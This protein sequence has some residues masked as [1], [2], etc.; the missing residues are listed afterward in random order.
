MAEPSLGGRVGGAVR[1]KLVQLVGGKLIFLIRILVLARI[2]APDAFGLIAVALIPIGL[3]LQVSDFGMAPALIQQQRVSARHYDV[4][5]TIGL[6]RGAAISVLVFLAAPWVAD[7]AG[8]PRAASIMQVLAL[9][10]LLQAAASIRLAELQRRLAFRPLA[11]VTLGEA[12]VNTGVSI[13][14]AP[15][16][17][18]WALVFG[19]LA[20]S[21]A[22]ASLSYGVAPHRPR[23]RLDR[24]AAATLIRF[25]RWI[26]AAGIVAV[27][28][29]S[30]L[31]LVISRG[32]GT[33]ALGLYFLAGRLTFMLGGAASDVAESVSFPIYARLQ[34][35]R[36]EA[37]RIFRRALTS[38][39]A[40]LVPLFAMIIAL[41][42]SLV[43]NVLGERWQGTVP[44][45][46]WLSVA[47]LIGILGDVTVPILK[48]VGRPSGILVL[49]TVQSLIL[50]VLAWEWTSRFGI[51][52]AALA[53]LPAVGS[54]LLLCTLFLRSLLPQPLSGL[55]APLLAV[56]GSSLIGA[57]AAIGIDRAVGGL[58]GLMLAA[59]GGGLTVL[60][61][62]WGLD[63]RFA[64]GLSSSLAA[65]FP[66]L[67][68]L[69]QSPNS[70]R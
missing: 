2:V 62:L 70:D 61:L 53:W 59:L 20:G 19:S 46:R 47:C 27:I 25:G 66:Q 17:G 30:V 29:N 1:W 68:P 35:D 41:A 34:S 50:V 56:A 23:L 48:G 21:T 22:L 52:G 33:E 54:S 4:A 58:P 10:P 8:E 43:D 16:L 6:V 15:A 44:V 32:L 24:A 7:L 67:A 5:W 26:F 69:L 9:Q 38:L 13:A 57:L 55:F 49:E 64:L 36:V 39:G 65:V 42:P 63:R 12:L 31:R 14:L 37:V 11:L 3:L 28:G 40:L 51:E 18:V 60:G 45:I